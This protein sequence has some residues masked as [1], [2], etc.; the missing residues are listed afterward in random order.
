[1]KKLL[2]LLVVISFLY[3]GTKIFLNKWYK[4]SETFDME[5]CKLYKAI[6]DDLNDEEMGLAVFSRTI[7]TASDGQS[8]QH[9]VV[10]H[11]FEIIPSGEIFCVLDFLR[12]NKKI[13]L[14]KDCE[15]L[16]GP[17]QLIPQDFCSFYLRRGVKVI[18]PTRPGYDIKEQKALVYLEIFT[19]FEN[20]RYIVLLTKRNGRW[21]VQNKIIVE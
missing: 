11:F 7:T 4:V 20:D 19:R 14:L 21:M 13:S 3:F 8:V 10:Q 18:A 15:F 9:V 2:I 1:M 6:L 12:K 16:G 17:Y 5:D